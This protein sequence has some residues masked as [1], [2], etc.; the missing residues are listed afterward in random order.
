MTGT[1]AKTIPSAGEVDEA[2]IL[3]AAANGDG[4]AFAQLYSVFSAR[5][6]G[7]ARA[8][9]RDPHLAQDVAQEV[10]ME[11]WRKAP[12]FD[13]AKGPAAHWVLMLTRSRA[14]DRV[15]SAE[16][17]RTRA[18][19]WGFRQEESPRD[20]VMELVLLGSEQAAVRDAIAELPPIQREAILLAYYGG[21]SC[22]QIGDTLDTPL[23]TV[24][25][26]IRSG[27]IKLRERLAATDGSP[28]IADGTAAPARP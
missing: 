13:P 21:L 28:T 23:G 4:A 3:V 19:N 25:T 20:V 5:V 27:L 17:S 14:I 18:S 24:K 10:F 15:R 8:V 6:L 12:A 26:R 1:T 2:L 9:I 22:S 7:L 16:L 11:I